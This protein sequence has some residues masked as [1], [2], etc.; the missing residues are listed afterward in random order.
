MSQD[1]QLAGSL[2]KCT[3][4]Y[5]SG[6]LPEVRFKLSD[7]SIYGFPPLEPRSKWPSY[8]AILHSSPAIPLNDR[9]NYTQ[10]CIPTPSDPI[11][12]AKHCLLMKRCDAQLYQT[13]PP[14]EEAAHGRN[15][16][17]EL[18]K[19]Q[20][21]GWSAAGGVWIYRLPGALFEKRSLEEGM[22]YLD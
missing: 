20:I 3:L 18:P 11:D 12:G 7:E 1:K 17:H 19:K 9:S 13:T 22:E 16:Y 10:E 21:M 8:F 2:D 15:P 14:W 6:P 5:L 4:S